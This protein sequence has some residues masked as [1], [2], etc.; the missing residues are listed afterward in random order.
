MAPSFN[1]FEVYERDEIRAAIRAVKDSIRVD[2]TITVPSLDADLVAW[3]VDR[4]A[5]GGEIAERRVGV[6]RFC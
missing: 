3:V 1:P 5:R 2:G 6:W 4:L